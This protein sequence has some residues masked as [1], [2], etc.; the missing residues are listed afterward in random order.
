M[1]KTEERKLTKRDKR[2][3]E[4]ELYDYRGK[5]ARAKQIDNE[6]T[7]IKISQSK[8]DGENTQKTGISDPTGKMAMERLELGQ[9]LNELLYQINRVD[10]AL[11]G[12]NERQRT[13]IKL[14]YFE[15]QFN[16]SIQKKLNVEKSQFYRIVESSLQVFADVVGLGKTKKGQSE[17]KPGNN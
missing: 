6:I 16:H 8:M 5:V 1:T 13:I 15:R 4:G 17:D 11:D 7:H 2:Q 3:I 10:N 14:K 12:M 9:E